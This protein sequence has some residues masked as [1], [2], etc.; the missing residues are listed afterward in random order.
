MKVIVNGPVDLDSRRR[1]SVH[2][3]IYDLSDLPEEDRERVLDDP[4]VEA[5]GADITDGALEL[6]R[7]HGVDLTTITGSGEAGRI[8]K[9][10][11]EAHITDEE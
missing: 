8:V 1:T 7:A 11:V 6:A 2:G 4:R 9:A 5:L 10:D 3:G